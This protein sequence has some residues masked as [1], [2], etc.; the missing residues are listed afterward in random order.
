VTRRGA[1]AAALFVLP[2]VAL[3]VAVLL[4]P[5][6]YVLYFSVT[7]DGVPTGEGYLD[8]FRSTLF[9][10]VL[11]TTLAISVTATVASVLLG[12]PVALHLS[13]QTARRRALLLPLVLLPF[14]TSILVKSYAFTILLGREGL[15][16]R[17]LAW[18]FGPDFNVQLIFNR[19]GVIIGMVNYLLPF[20]V[21]PLLANL[22][23]QDRNL[24]QAA[25][26]MGASPT[27]IFWKVTL[28]QSMPALA[29]GAL[30]CLILSFGFFVTPAILGGRQ[31]MMLA[32]LID[33]FTRET[34][35]WTASSAIAVVLLLLSAA[36]VV[37]LSR[38][39]GAR[40]RLA[41]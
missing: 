35:N 5:L 39:P 10:R 22:L 23:A 21:F 28:P 27:R 16:N 36:V 6:G 24:T 7:K 20:I 17:A 33:M 15:V 1:P 14:W 26:S 32:N 4:V 41:T 2:A 38:I 8:L 31:D 25:E 34:L 12:Y 37:L 19:T 3:M 11:G 9:L 40:E 29:S 18:L 13:R 30:L